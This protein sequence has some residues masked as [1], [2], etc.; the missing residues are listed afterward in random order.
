DIVHFHAVASG[1]VAP[2]PRYLSRAKVVLTVH[3]L[4]HDRAKWGRVARAALRAGAHLSARVPDAT[5][6]VSQALA[7]HFAATYGR[8]ATYIPNGIP[9]AH[10][11]PLGELGPRFGIAPGRYLLFVGRLVP[12]KAP[13]LL[14]RAFAK[15][16]TDARLVIAG[17]S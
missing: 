14:L 5:I 10:L 7:D 17:G 15:V 11:E 8:R 3:G 16:D 2:L 9:E 6:T 1:L 12:E 13:D 4:D